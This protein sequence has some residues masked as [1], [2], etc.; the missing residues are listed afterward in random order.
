MSDAELQI[1]TYIYNRNAGVAVSTMVDLQKRIIGGHECERPYHVRL[2]G[3]AVN[4]SSSLCGGSLISERWILTAA[5]CVEPGRTIFADFGVLLD[6]AAQEVQITANPVI[7]TDKDNNNNHRQHDLM[8][9]Q[10]PG[11]SNIQPVALPDCG[12]QPGM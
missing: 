7:Y 9:L 8:L 1:K 2:R 6:G 10:L 3:V 4:R 11:N 12:D 5:H